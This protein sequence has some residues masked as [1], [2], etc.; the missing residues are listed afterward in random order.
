MNGSI[1]IGSR[2]TAPTCPGAAAGGSLPSVAPRYTPCTQLNA[3]Y[4]SGTLLLRRPPKMIA[5]T[6]TPA[7][8]LAAPSSTGL[9]AIGAV[10]R[11]FACAALRP[12]SGVH[13]C[14]VQSTHSAG[15]SSVLPSHQTSPS[16]SSATLV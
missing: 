10:K 13:F 14:P 6:R 9:F 12:Q 1:A 7:G 11:L 4:T 16:G 5:L 3:W 2:R 15:G 8:S